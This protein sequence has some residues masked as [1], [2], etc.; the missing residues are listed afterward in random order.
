MSHFEVLEVKVSKQA[1]EEGDTIQLITMALKP[2][3]DEPSRWKDPGSLNLS[4]EERRQGVRLSLQS[5][6]ALNNPMDCSPP[7]WKVS[8]LQHWQVGSLPLAAP[9]KPKRRLR[10]STRNISIWLHETNKWNFHFANSDCGIIY[11]S[12]LFTHSAIHIPPLL[13]LSHGIRH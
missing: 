8:R 4:L 5:F 6:P 12:G 3:D 13:S 9:G 10:T 7:G 1:F 11:N 2:K